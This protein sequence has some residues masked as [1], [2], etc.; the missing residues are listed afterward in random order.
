M[1]E[2]HIEKY[3]RAQTKRQH[4]VRARTA[5]IRLR[6]SSTTLRWVRGELLVVLSNQKNSSVQI[7]SLSLASR[8][9]Y[10]AQLASHQLGSGHLNSA[11]VC[12]SNDSKNSS[13][14]FHSPR[15]RSHR[16]TSLR[17]S[18]RSLQARP[19]SL[20]SSAHYLEAAP[21]PDALPRELQPASLPDA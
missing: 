16:I 11:P 17:L 5:L 2:S 15:I 19:P 20:E 8:Q 13:G 21:M 10:S 14:R 1:V 12:C 3:Q 7:A 6:H 9:L 4:E 18:Y